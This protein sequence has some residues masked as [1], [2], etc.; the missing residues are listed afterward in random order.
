[1]LNELIEKIE[2]NVIEA[3]SP[4]GL[5]PL[6]TKINKEARSFVPDTSTEKGRNEII[7]ICKQL[8]K[9]SKVID[10]TG[11]DYVGELK[12]IPKIVDTERKRSR[13]F[14]ESL[15]DE[16]RDPLT[17]WEINEKNRVDD[18][19]ERINA[20]DPFKRGINTIEVGDLTV[21][22]LKNLIQIADEFV[23]DES[24]AEYQDSAALC[25][26]ETLLKLSGLLV[27][28]EKEDLQRRQAEKLKKEEEERVQQELIDAAAK[29]A[30]EKAEREAEDLAEKVKREQEHRERVARQREEN[31]KRNAA[32][33]LERVKQRALDD[34]KAA[35]RREETAKIQARKDA[36]Q[37]VLA[38][39]QKMAR[40]IAR[41][42]EKQ[43][44][45][46]SNKKHCAVI[47]NAVV[48]DLMGIGLTEKKSKDVVKAIAK[49]EISN[50]SIKY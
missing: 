43:E 3:F 5:N 40:E 49:K 35:E 22:E 30:K 2:L 11:K 34:K 26:N 4:L 6:L 50:V 12:K 37:L 48:K 33:E 18:I 47:N 23:V 27:M 42:R 1:M 32:E 31:E 16:I 15:E 36:E 38:T 9:A 28:Q 17:K 10:K 46:S 20:I 8:V 29:A 19:L 14:L 7:A 25:K 21:R 39:Q 13:D 44:K 41:E 45:L 24:L